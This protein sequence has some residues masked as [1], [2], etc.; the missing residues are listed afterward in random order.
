M[1]TSGEP[2]TSTAR[3]VT[4]HVVA[5]ARSAQQE[6]ARPLQTKNRNNT[7]HEEDKN[8]SDRFGATRWW[9]QLRGQFAL[10]LSR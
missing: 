2:D 4:L 1:N 9:F 3:T 10:I 7:T 8:T 6:H 5:V